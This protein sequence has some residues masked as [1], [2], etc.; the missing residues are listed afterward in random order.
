MQRD[1]GLAEDGAKAGSP[2]VLP[3]SRTEA[4]RRNLRLAVFG[5]FAR[6][7]IGLSALT[8]AGQ[9]SFVVALPVLSRLYT[10]T[11]FGIFTIYLSI[12]NIGGPLVGL[13][14]DSAIF[15]ART[16]REAAATLALSLLTIV[17]MTSFA[18][19]ALFVFSDE[20]AAL[21]GHSARRIQI[22]LPLGLLLSGAWSTSSAW[23]IKSEATATLSIARFGQPALMTLLQLAAG[24]GTAAGGVSLV[25]AHLVSHLSYSGFIFLRTLSRRDF[26][27]VDFWRW[28]SLALHANRNRAFPS[29]VLPAQISALSV[30]NLPPLLLSL[31]YGAEIAGH[32]GIAYRLVSAPLTIAS[33][34]LGAI[35]TSVVSRSPSPATTD[36]LARKVF[37]SNV[38]L[39]SLP[40]LALGAVAPT[41]APVALG[42]HWARAGQIVAAFALLGAAQSL[43]APFTE[44]TSIFRSQV[45]RMTIEVVTAVIVIAVIGLGALNSWPALQTIWAMSAAGAASSMLGL[46][47]VFLRLRKMANRT[48]ADAPTPIVATFAINSAPNPGESSRLFDCGASSTRP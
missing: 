35:F 25:L 5:P 33:M 39:V 10:P 42:G 40:V 6:K 18:A 7:V 1:S 24:L 20:V 26:D 12:V 43:A 27:D 17:V 2:F 38:F 15:A 34:P 31:V 23:A 41:L 22:I 28:R 36:R 46:F 4:W 45:L 48:A 47:A 19:V 9:L 30:S 3:P 29:F 21:A 11:D 8:A 32:C 14:F 37:I 44:I 13:K 16:R